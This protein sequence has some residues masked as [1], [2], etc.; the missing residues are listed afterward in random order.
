MMARPI[1]KLIYFLVLL[2]GALV[3]VGDHLTSLS[4]SGPGAPG[5]LG[6][7]C[8]PCGAPCI[9]TDGWPSTVAITS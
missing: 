7:A 2:A 6:G 1:P 9:E 3:V 4:L 8:A 5:D